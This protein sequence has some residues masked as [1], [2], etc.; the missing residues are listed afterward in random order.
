MSTGVGKVPLGWSP[1]VHAQGVV[2]FSPVCSEEPTGAVLR[3]RFF[4]V[5]A[6]VDVFDFTLTDEEMA[7][8]ATLDKQQPLA[9]FTHRDPRMLERLQSLD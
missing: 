1:K 8:I 4:T 6:C 3:H 7:G 5:S 2:G 9:G